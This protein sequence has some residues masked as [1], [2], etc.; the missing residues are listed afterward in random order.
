MLG[1][2]YHPILT[3][4]TLNGRWSRVLTHYII[5]SLQCD[6]IFST[7]RNFDDSLMKLTK[8][9]MAYNELMICRI[10][11]TFEMYVNK[12][13][14]SLQGLLI[15]SNRWEKRRDTKQYHHTVQCTL[16]S[17]ISCAI[18]H[19]TTICAL[20]WNLYISTLHHAIYTY[21]MTNT[22]LESLSRD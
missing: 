17:T 15:H 21:I 10:R 8:I 7:S 14:I 11:F 6:T 5:I 22:A 12:F 18:V 16:S 13:R 1:A 9:I 2:A 4:N 19:T 20:C 3:L